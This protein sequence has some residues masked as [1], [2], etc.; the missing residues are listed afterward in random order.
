MSPKKNIS[1]LKYF[2]LLC[3]LPIASFSH[4]SSITLIP[5]Y[6]TSIYRDKTTKII[7]HLQTEKNNSARLHQASYFFLRKP[8]LLGALG[9]GKYGQYDQNP[10]YR[11]DAFDCETY[12]DT[13]LALFVSHNINDFEKNIISIR[14]ANNIPSFRTRNHFTHIDWNTHNQRKGYITDITATLFPQ[15]HKI[16]RTYINKPAWF[17]HLSY[18]ALKLLAAPANP[19][20][21]LNRLHAESKKTKG[22]LSV[23]NYIPLSALF[24]HQGN[25]NM[26]LFNR[27]PDNVVIE[28]VRPNWDLQK[29]I[30]TQLDISHM[31]F[32]IYQHAQL[33]FRQA[34]T[35]EKK[36]I[37]IPLI[38]YL[39]NYINSTTVKGIHIEKINAAP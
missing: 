36:V 19:N 21:L 39:R 26:A 3:L 32:G 30:G 14:Y 15:E 24:D 31:G 16:S 1:N 34:S 28:I 9:E 8:Y 29:A 37:D 4:A 23:L 18:S 33:I 6:D 2:L 22:Q 35:V 27:I 17:N 11:T 7:K 13:V 20:E 12:V 38:E 10:L 5:S 25:P